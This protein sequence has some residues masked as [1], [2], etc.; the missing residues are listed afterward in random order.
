[1]SGLVLMAGS[2]F[3]FILLFFLDTIAFASNPYVGILTFLVAPG[4]FFA[5]LLVFLFGAW[6]WRR[7]RTKAGVLGA[8]RINIDFSRAHDRRMLG[9]FVA[10]SAC[11]LLLTAMG[12][13]NT[14]HFTE[15]VEFCGEACHT[16]MKPE[17]T[18]YL[19]SPHARV[20]CAECHIGKGASWY[21]RS[22]LSGTYQVYAT[23]M[24]KYPTPIPTPVKNLRPAQETCEQCHWPKKFVGNL[25][26]TLNYYL[27]DESNSLYSVRLLLNVGGAD[28]THG[29]VGGIH[30]H[31][32][33]ANKIEYI[34]A[35]EGRKKIPWVRMTDPQGVVTEYRTKEFTNDV[36]G[37]TPRRM[38]CM[39]CHNRPAHKFQ[40]PESAVNL[41]MSLGN[42]DVTLPYIKTNA[43]GVLSRNYTNQ[44]QALQAIATTLSEKFPNDPRIR[45]AIAAV[46]QIYT[47]NFF[48]EM[49]ADWRDYP[50]N[51]GHKD[52]PGCFRCHD[53]KHISSTG[54]EMIKS[55]DCNACHRIL[56]Q[57]SGEQLKQ[58]NAE[59]QKF[60]HPID[61]YD[62]SFQCTDCHEPTR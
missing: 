15:S 38:D 11:F 45:G 44:T 36:S 58:L 6:R 52:F 53:G 41:A 19:H 59:G 29:P 54:R 18:T 43:V 60:A 20:A 62:P 30:W 27:P 39:D 8:L 28:P 55:N 35:D 12:S 57:G 31:M 47:N 23:V 61:E 40:S 48:P 9:Y 51:I 21:V 50:D 26:R 33:V 5:G 4:F 49:K 17:L 42:I 56:A 2:I 24:D 3:A 16:V 14:Y 10:G 32:N 22:K 13:Y 34:A 25:D 37:M 46:Q 1:M 7:K